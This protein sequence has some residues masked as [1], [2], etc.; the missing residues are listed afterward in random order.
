MVF[1]QSLLQGIFPENFKVSK[2]TPIAKGGE[3]M[4]PYNYRP[5]STLRLCIKSDFRKT[6]L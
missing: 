6:H 2:V 3:E 1:N 4:D 5:I